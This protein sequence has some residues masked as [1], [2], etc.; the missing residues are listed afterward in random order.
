MFN[1][2]ELPFLLVMTLLSVEWFGDILKSLD[3]EARCVVLQNKGKPVH[4]ITVISNYPV[5]QV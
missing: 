1:K 2:V 3:L 4:Q 5:Q